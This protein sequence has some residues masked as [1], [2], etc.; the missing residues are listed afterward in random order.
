VAL[1][2][3]VRLRR[4]REAICPAAAHAMPHRV[5]T[6]DHIGRE[7]DAAL[8]FDDSKCPFSVSNC[9]FFFREIAQFRLES[10]LSW[11]DWIDDSCTPLPEEWHLC[12][13]FSSR[14]T[15]Y[16]FSPFRNPQ[17]KC[18]PNLY[19]DLEKVFQFRIIHSDSEEQQQ[20]IQL[21]ER[22]NISDDAEY[23][24]DSDSDSYE[25]PQSGTGDCIN[26]FF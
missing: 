25:Y 17:L 15:Y 8:C 10:L 3:G 6:I 19:N 7:T 1:H 22:A 26:S 21:G 18:L 24:S 16:A 9:S 14:F 2:C 4:R 20:S 23:A 13:D 5:R 11:Q 12:T